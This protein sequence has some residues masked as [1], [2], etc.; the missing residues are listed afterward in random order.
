MEAE[1]EEVIKE[2][3]AGRWTAIDENSIDELGKGDRVEGLFSLAL[4]SSVLEAWGMRTRCT[5]GVSD[6]W[7]K[8]DSGEQV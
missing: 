3:V 5:S 4:G 1:T 7:E 6:E 8:F 2:Q